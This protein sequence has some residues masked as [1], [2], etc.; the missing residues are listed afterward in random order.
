MP[1]LTE[2]IWHLIDD[3]TDDI[4]VSDWPN[5]KNVEENLLKNLILFRGNFIYPKIQENK[6]KFQ[7]K[8]KSH[9]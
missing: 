4:I 3:R 5:Q 6:N 7:T 9:Y 8:I 1:F 2:E